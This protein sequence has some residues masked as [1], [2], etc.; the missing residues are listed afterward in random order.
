M[1]AAPV[2]YF[3]SFA[4]FDATYAWRLLMGLGL[5]NFMK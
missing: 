5:Q 1:V 3:V 2:L 4:V